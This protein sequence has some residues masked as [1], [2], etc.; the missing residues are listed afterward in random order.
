MTTALIR[1]VGIAPCSMELVARRISAT[2]ANSAAV[3]SVRPTPAELRDRWRDPNFPKAKLQHFIEYDNQ[4][5]K[6]R[7]RELLSSP[8]FIPVY[9]QSLPQERQSALVRLKKVCDEGFISVL[10]FIHN[11]LWVFAAHEY[12]SVIDGAM[13]TKLTVQFN[14]FGGTVLKIGTQ[15]H[16]DV[17]LKG[18]DTLEDIGCF[19]LTELGYGNNAVQMETTA[20]YDKETDELIVNTPSPLAQ[21]YWITNG[22][23][24]AHHIVVFAQLHVNGV[25]EGIHGVLV[26]I[27]NKDMSVRPGVT[28]HDMGHKIGLNGIDN[29]KFYF[30]NVRVPRTNLLNAHADISPEGVFATTVKGSARRRFL[31]LADQLLSGRLCIAS[32][33]QGAA[34]TCMTIAVRYSAARLAVGPDGSS[35]S[36]ILSYQLQQNALMPL[37]ANTVIY[38]IALSYIKQRWADQNKDDE[39]DVTEVV[40]LCCAIKAITGWHV[41][42]VSNLGRERCGGAGYLSAN[43]FGAAMSGSHSSITAEGDNSV[44]MMKTASEYLGLFKKSISD[45]ASVAKHYA[46]TFGRSMSLGLLGNT[47]L[48]SV[49]AIH[50]VLEDHEYSAAMQLGMK[51]AK[52]GKKGY[53]ETW[54]HKEQHLVQELG[55]AYG[56]RVISQAAKDAISKADPEIKPILT[57]LYHM[58]LMD[59]LEKKKGHLYAEGLITASTLKKVS[60]IHRRL[61]REIGPDALNI[62]DSFGYTD[63]MLSAPIARDW[64]SWNAVDNRGE[65]DAFDMLG[66]GYEPVASENNVDEAAESSDDEVIAARA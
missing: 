24:H 42:V 53:F 34:K 27:R 44:L 63:E 57:K 5:K 56:D 48:E 9:D 62:V 15:R 43:R 38:D 35:S 45:P 8:E 1:R 51:M 46:K 52:A 26:P 19:G 58:Y 66:L 64:H 17:L 40:M 37:L 28:I 60:Q 16:H 4:E 2:A 32:M 50:R 49:E 3:A 31:V 12:A 61:T 29:A 41:N 20:V 18:I 59:V 21:K 33:S 54:V 39:R 6:A 22:A 36:P 11:P 65:V 7:F 25:N 55:R 10:D 23:L 14:L 30:D 47:N 13:A